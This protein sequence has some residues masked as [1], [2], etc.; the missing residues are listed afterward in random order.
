[1]TEH[2]KESDSPRERWR[3]AAELPP[4]V[5]EALRKENLR[6]NPV[7]VVATVDQDGSPHAAPF[8]SVRAITPRTLRMLCLHYHDTYA[9]VCRDGRVTVTVLSPPDIAVT[10]RGRARVVRERL[11]FHEHSAALEIEV[12]EVK[13]DMPRTGLIGS[14]ITFFP[15]DEFGAWFEGVLGELEA[16]TA[17]SAA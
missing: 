12:E 17:G 3:R 6:I 14:G 9:N 4:E 16:M 1:M 8:G 15:K 2:A 10:I 13:N 11:E 7:A 5:M